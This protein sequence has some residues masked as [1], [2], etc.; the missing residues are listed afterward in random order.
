LRSS[1]PPPPSAKRTGHA[2]R[3]PDAGAL[4]FGSVRD[5]VSPLID[6]AK[7]YD[8]LCRLESKFRQGALGEFRRHDHA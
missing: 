2:P 5:S 8:K 6:E 1:P 3:F 4:L 7:A